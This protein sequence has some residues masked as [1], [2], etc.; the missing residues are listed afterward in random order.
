ML[1]G[2]ERMKARD[3]DFGC[4]ELFTSLFR[5]ET[6]GLVKLERG[7]ISTQFS[8]RTPMDAHTMD[9]KRMHA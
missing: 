6:L 9:I 3:A 5:L 2:R 8:H 7:A 1:C 4:G